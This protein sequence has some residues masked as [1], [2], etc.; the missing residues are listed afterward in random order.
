M[1]AIER[2]QWKI[3]ALLAARDHLLNQTPTDVVAIAH[4]TEMIVDLNVRQTAL[5]NLGNL[6]TSSAKKVASL[7]AALLTLDNAIN[8]SA[9][10]PEILSAATT[11]ASLPGDDDTPVKG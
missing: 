9:A 11:L 4:L 6:R 3:Q 1:D 10:V 5:S 8:E 2:I 7:K